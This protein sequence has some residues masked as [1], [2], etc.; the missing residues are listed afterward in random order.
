MKKVVILG[1][2]GSLGLKSIE[3]LNKYRRHFK[4]IGICANQNEA[5]LK[6]QGALLQ[7]P[8]KNI[9]LAKKD[10]PLK[11]IKLSILKEA[12]I[13]INVLSSVAGINPTIQALKSNKTVLLGNKESIIAKGKEIIYL[14]G[15]NNTT[16]IPLDSEHNAIFEILKKHPN[17]KIK[18]IIIPCSGGPFLNN[19]QAQLKTVT[20]KEALN[21]PKWKMGPKI[22]IESA[23]LLNKGFE[24]IEA[25][26]L[27]NLPLSKIEAKIHPQCQVHA[28]V[29]FK[30][31][32][33]IA[34]VSSPDMSEHIENAL[35]HAINKKT[36]GSK[37]IAPLSAKFAFLKV[38]HEKLPGIEIVL[39]AF[40]KNPNAMTKFLKKEEKVISTFLNGKIKFTEIFEKLKSST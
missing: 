38:P 10:G 33:K 5:L 8:S 25:H 24:I 15:K 21:H 22:T 35:L 12:D 31:G 17:E 28:I 34:Y 4:I 39:N 18:K 27:F 23:T 26:Y 6:K 7:I 9:A 16:L 13:I 36:P 3:I 40:K 11:I 20:S 30:S 37:K 19:S 29:E 1:S 2:T 14:A 32:K